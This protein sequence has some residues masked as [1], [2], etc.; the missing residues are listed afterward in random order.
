MK[1]KYTLLIEKYNRFH[2]WEVRYH[3]QIPVKEHLDRFVALC[4][5]R[6]FFD[7]DTIQK[8]QQEHLDALIQTEKQFKST[9]VS[10]Q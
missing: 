2:E 6:K 3:K 8:M 1:N 4:R 7:A 5:L 10:T 9:D